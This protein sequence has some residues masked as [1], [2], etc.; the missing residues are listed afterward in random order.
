MLQ[1][2]E[3]MG[4]PASPAVDTAKQDDDQQKVWHNDTNI[5]LAVSLHLDS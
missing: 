2:E 3:L 5:F 1:C 4:S